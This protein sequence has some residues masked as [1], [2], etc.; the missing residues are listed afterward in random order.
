MS[1]A[2]VSHAL[3]DCPGSRDL[4]LSWRSSVSIGDE[5]SLPWEELRLELFA[6]RMGL[7]SDDAA[8]TE[9]RVL[10]VGRVFARAAQLSKL[11]LP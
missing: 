3:A 6:G 1:D 11:T 2:T 10:F 8:A 5:Y 4:Y 9:A 7:L